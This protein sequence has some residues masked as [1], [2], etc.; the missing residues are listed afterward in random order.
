MF[1]ARSQ[2]GHGMTSDRRRM[3]GAVAAIM[4]LMAVAGAQAAD[5]AMIAAAQ[6][7]GQVVWYTSFVEAQL[8]RPLAAAFERK[9]PGIKVQLVA[10]TVTDLLLKLLAETKAGAIRGD[11]HHG[12][13]SLWPLAKAGAV[14]SYRPDAAKTYPDDR[15]DPEGMWVADAL[16]FLVAAVN[17]DMVAAADEPRTYEDLLDPRWQGKIAWTN[18]LTQGGTAGFIGTVLQSMGE[19]RGMD[20]LRRLAAQKLVS[21]PSNQRAVLDQVIAGEYPLALAIFNNHADLSAAKGAP[22]K[23]LRLE[24]VTATLDTLFLLKGPHPN[25]GKLFVEYVLSEEGQAA[26]AKA[27]YLPADPRVPATKPDEKPEGGG[28][29]TQLL[30]PDLVASDL[31]KWIAVYHA[32]FK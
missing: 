6:K 16:Y 10:G 13:S 24:P 9:Y 27:G 31:P 18:Q 11:V 8:A 22:V 26:I 7:E 23:W 1:G 12:G 21:V 32:L 29:R 28:F 3:I 25:A 14:A 17:T 15:K 20:F 19:E 30:S 2:G 5:P 4:A